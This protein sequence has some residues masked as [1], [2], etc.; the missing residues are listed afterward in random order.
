MNVGWGGA[1]VVW[2]GLILVYG[3]P[4]LLV[5]IV[6]WLGSFLVISRVMGGGTGP[7]VM[8]GLGWTLIVGAL[9][10]GLTA[11]GRITRALNRVDDR[12][13]VSEVSASGA[14]TAAPWMIVAGAAFIAIAVLMS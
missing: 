2:V 6:T 9:A 12:A 14:G 3:W 11:A 5:A 7:R 10:A 8:L 1:L 13:P 4:L